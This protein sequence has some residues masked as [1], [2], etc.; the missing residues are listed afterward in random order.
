MPSLGCVISSPMAVMLARSS[1]PHGKWAIEI[2]KRLHMAKRLEVVPRHC[3]A[4]RTFASLNR[5][6][7]L[8][9]DFERIIAGTAARLFIDLVKQLV[10]RIVT[11]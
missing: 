8:A 10:W 9:E 3:V 4:E 11:Q 1:K 6:C 5:N 2:V 7:R